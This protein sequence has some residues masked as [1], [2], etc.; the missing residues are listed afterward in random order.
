MVDAAYKAAQAPE[1]PQLYVRRGGAWGQVERAKL[2][3]GETCFVK[4]ENGAMEAVGV[5]DSRGEAARYPLQLRLCA[6]DM[7]GVRVFKGR[8]YI[9]PQRLA[10]LRFRPFLFGS[11]QLKLPY[12][13]PYG[14]RQIVNVALNRFGRRRGRGGDKRL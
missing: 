12:L 3:P 1:P 5:V 14:Q 4:R 9:L 7:G 6:A 8:G 11:G 13:T 2:K 10:R